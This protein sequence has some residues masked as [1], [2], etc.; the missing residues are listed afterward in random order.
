MDDTTETVDPLQFREACGR[1][2]TGVT[3]M[4]AVDGSGRGVGVTVN[5]FSSVSLDPPLVQFSLDR[6]ASTFH[7]FEKADRFVVNVLARDQKE[8]S[9]RFADRSDFEGLAHEHWDGGCP[10]LPGCLATIGCEGYATY[11]GG[12]HLIILGRV[13]RIEAGS[14]GEPLLFFRGGYGTFS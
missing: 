9:N 1:Y 8:I 7:V 5:S 6:G 12:D 10:V 4:T 14:P 2:A 13:S 3:V 11:D